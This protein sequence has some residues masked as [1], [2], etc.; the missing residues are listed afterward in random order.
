M[1]TKTWQEQCGDFAFEC[2]IKEVGGDVRAYFG[3]DQTIA[4]VWAEC[5]KNE[6]ILQLSALYLTGSSERAG[7]YLDRLRAKLVE[8]F[9]LVVAP[10]K[11]SE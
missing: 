4:Q 2:V 7:V 5:H 3:S 9:G 8:T 1:S 11:V 10:K 6:T